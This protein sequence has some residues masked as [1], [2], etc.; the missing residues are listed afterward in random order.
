MQTTQRGPI[1]AILSWKEKEYELYDGEN[2][3]G[4]SAKC[5]I[6]IDHQILKLGVGFSSK[7]LG[8]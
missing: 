4:R 3:I 2:M 7:I 6:V 1:Q 8:L 5:D